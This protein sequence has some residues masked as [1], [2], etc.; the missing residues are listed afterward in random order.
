[1]K[2]EACTIE[3]KNEYLPIGKRSYKVEINFEIPGGKCVFS[4][5]T[6]ESTNSAIEK[7]YE[8]A[9]ARLKDVPGG[10]EA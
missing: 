1:M 6:S 10:P 7:A 5:S 9:A 2:I 8:I 3:T 4:I